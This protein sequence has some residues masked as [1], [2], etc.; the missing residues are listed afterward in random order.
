MEPKI[1]KDPL[2]P[3]GA[4]SAAF[5]FNK[6]FN[7]LKGIGKE[8][9]NVNTTLKLPDEKLKKINQLKDWLK[10]NKAEFSKIEYPVFFSER[11]GINYLG[12][13]AS[14]DINANE[15]LIKIPEKC[16][17]SSD[18]AFKSEIAVI[19]NEN[20][21]LFSKLGIPSYWKSIFL[22]KKKYKR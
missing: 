4:I 6:H 18:K 22:G 9:Q 13:L 7:L 16:L 1:I 15:V 19:F 12:C 10:S 17:L 21:N 14:S 2:A 8:A 3:K 20:P 5:S 11:P